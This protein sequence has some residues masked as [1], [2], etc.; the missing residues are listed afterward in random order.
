L[1][2]LDALKSWNRQCLNDII[3]E[4][5]NE[6]GLQLKIVNQVLRY[7]IAGLESGV[8]IHVIIEILGKE[9]VRQRLDTCIIYEK[10]ND[11]H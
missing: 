6:L 8:G 2:K 5:G 3:K 4:I 7:A 11:A 10:G 1:Q 9:R